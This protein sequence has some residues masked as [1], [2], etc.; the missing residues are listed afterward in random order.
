MENSTAIRNG[1]TSRAGPDSYFMWDTR[2]NHSDF[3]KAYHAF[4]PTERVELQLVSHLY[5][6]QGQ[7]AISLSSRS[8]ILTRIKKTQ[9]TASLNCHCYWAFYPFIGVRTN[10]VNPILTDW[11]CNVAHHLRGIVFTRSS[12]RAQSCTFFS[13]NFESPIFLVLIEFE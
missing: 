13:S 12:P 6:D 11:V 3:C 8:I 9:L 2:L 5:E 7:L 10:T 1:E 4:E